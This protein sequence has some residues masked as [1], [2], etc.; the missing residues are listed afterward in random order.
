MPVAG[1][2]SLGRNIVTLH[3]MDVARQVRGGV[4]A[5]IVGT[6]SLVWRLP[7]RGVL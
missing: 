5:P 7:S 3:P 1:V 2:A 4:T 6:A